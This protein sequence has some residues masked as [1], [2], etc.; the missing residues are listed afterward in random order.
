MRDGA[1]PGIYL[2]VFAHEYG[3][4]AQELAGVLETAQQKQYDDGQD[5]AAGLEFSRRLELQAQ[6]FSGMFL[7]SSVD[8]GGDVDRNHGTNAHAESWWHQGAMKNRTQ[9]C[10]TW[11]ATSAD[12]A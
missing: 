2:A 9:Q 5:S 6:C 1:H 11:A 8:R 12:V 4:R 10:N 3:H 7:G